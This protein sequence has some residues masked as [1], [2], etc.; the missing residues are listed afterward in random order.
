MKLAPVTLV[1]CVG[2]LVALGFVM[3]YSARLAN[4][5]KFSPSPRVSLS[6]AAELAVDAEAAP[7]PSPAPKRRDRDK[8]GEQLLAAQL[9]YCALGFLGA[10]AASLLDHRR[11][12]MLAWPAVAVAFVLLVLVLIPGVGKLTNG[13]RR[14]LFHFQPS[15]PAKLALVL[16]LAHYGAAQGQKMGWFLRGFVVPGALLG[17]FLVLIFLEPDWGTTILLATVGAGT[18]YLSGTRLRYLV[19]AALLGAGAIF[20]LLQHNPV[21]MSRMMAFLHPEMYRDGVGFQTWQAMLA[22]GSGGW[23]GLGLGNGR[24]KLGFVPENQTDF[25]L[26]VIGEE[27]G[28]VATLSVVVVYLILVVCGFA[29]ARRAGSYFGFLLGSSITFM[30]GLQ[31]FINI[32]VVTS[33][34]PNKGLPLPFIS[35]GGSNLVV[36]L[37]CAGL[38]LGVARQPRD[39]ASEEEQTLDRTDFP[40]GEKAAALPF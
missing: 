11:L 14:W 19:P 26:S 32:A 35:Y 9:S 36:M 30:I 18:M 17:T 38:L 23:D 15:E 16:A 37:I 34:L 22:L 2:A 8:T 3:L 10:V 5:V 20:L 28:L 1:C 29:I 39:A 33:M 12:R 13:A 40:F 6:G 7:A 21:R 31:A 27:L 4:S 24:Q 25:I